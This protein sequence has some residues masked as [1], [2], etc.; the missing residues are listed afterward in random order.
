MDWS[1]VR[2]NFSILNEITYINAASVGL[3][4]DTAIK[5][6]EKWLS[7]RRY[8]NIYWLE[9]YKIYENAIKLFAKLIN[10]SENEVTGVYNTSEGLNFIANSIDWRKGGNIITNDLEFPTNLFI[11]QVISKRYGLELKVIRNREGF[12]DIREYEEAINDKTIAIAVSWVEFSNGYV[13]DLEKLAK[14]A[15]DHEAYL[16]VDG[17]Q[18]TGS[19]PLDV[20][21]T[22]ID[23]LS[24]GGHKWL[25]GLSGAGFLYV[26]SEVLEEL[27]PPFAGWL[28]DAEPF[29]FDYREYKPHPSARRFDLGSQNFIGYVVLNNTLS[30]INEIGIRNIYDKNM[31]LAKILAESIDNI[32]EIASPMPNGKLMSPIVSI[33]INNAEEIYQKLR[34]RKIYIA[35][36]AGNLRVSPH[37]YNNEED[38]NK[39]VEELRRTIIK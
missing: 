17:I 13:H 31:R 35:L 1:K 19:L 4:P 32:A 8:G 22:K 25:M 14:L 34:E 16:I 11:W 39:F 23:F 33:K 38:I 10:A 28:G 20:K 36:R 3:I 15:H 37:L 7:E 9:W 27:H 6:A 26:R 29:R 18:G 30:L 2:E 5:E 21:R 12:I 24:C